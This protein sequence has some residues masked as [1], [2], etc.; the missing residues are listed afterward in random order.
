MRADVESATVTATPDQVPL[1]E[2]ARSD[3]IDAGRI[4]LLM[5]RPGEG[6]LTVDVVL[7]PAAE[8]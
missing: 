7:A 8:A 2:A 4:Q 6:E 5:I 3:L 1:I